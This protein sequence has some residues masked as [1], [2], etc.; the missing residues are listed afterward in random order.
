MARH[1]LSLLL[2]PQT[3]NV[4]LTFYK[5]KNI[6]VLPISGETESLNTGRG[7]RCHD[8]VMITVAEAVLTRLDLVSPPFDQ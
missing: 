8:V 3:H 1:L 2:L 7:L 6:A 5:R 4:C